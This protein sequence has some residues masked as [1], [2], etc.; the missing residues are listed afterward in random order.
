MR[1]Q[2]AKTDSRLISTWIGSL[3]PRHKFRRM[4]TR[5]FTHA[6]GQTRSTTNMNVPAQQSFRITLPGRPAGAKWI[7]PPRVIDR[8]D[9]RADGAGY[10]PEGYSHIFVIPSD[11]GS[12]RQL[13]EGDYNHG[14][15]EWAPD[16]Q[17]II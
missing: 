17:T 10:R 9:Y 3:S 6:A 14:A 11:G 8:L 15:P 13:T 12:P 1:W 2:M 16:S 5:S 4:A 7:D